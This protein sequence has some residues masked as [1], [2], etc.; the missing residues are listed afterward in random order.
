MLVVTRTI[1][2]DLTEDCPFLL[3]NDGNSIIKIFILKDSKSRNRIRL[4]VT[5]PKEFKIERSERIDNEKTSRD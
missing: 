1:E 4:A 5:A 3:I 2:K